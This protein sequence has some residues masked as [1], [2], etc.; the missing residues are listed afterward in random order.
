LENGSIQREK[1]QCFLAIAP[2]D[3]QVPDNIQGII[4][5]R[6]DRLEDNIKRTMQLA[7]VIGRD[8]AFRIL[9]TITGMKKELKSYLLNLQGLEF[10]YE[11]RLFPELEYIFKHALTQE[12]A[13]NSLLLKRRKEIHGKIG[14]AIEELYP[15]RLEEF[16]EMLAYHFDQG[17]VW[18]KAVVY[19]VK[20]GVKTRQ[21]FALQLAFQYF[22]RAKEILEKHPPEVPWQVRYDLFFGRGQILGEMGQWPL[23]CQEAKTAV[24]IAHREGS[25]DRWMKALFA[26]AFAA[27][28]GHLIDDLKATLADLEPIV[29]DDPKSLLGAAALQTMVNFISDDIPSA[30]AGEKNVDELIRLAPNSPF[31]EP[32][33]MWKGFFHRWRGDF[34]KCSQIFERLLPRMKE[35]AP[36]TVYLQSLFFYGLAMGEQGNYQ[37]AIEILEAGRQHGLE[38]GE[39]YSTPKVTN[40]LGWAYHE[41]C[42]FDKAIEYNNLSLDSFKELLGPRTSNLFEI[43]SHTRLNLG[44]NYLMKGNFKKALEHLELVY[45][46][47]LK[48]EY[49]FNLWRYKPRCLL[50]LGELW[51]QK[52]DLSKAQF[53]Q[54]EVTDH[55]WTTKFPYKK[56]QVRSGR[57]QGNIYAAQGRFDAAETELQQSLKCAKQLGNPTQ[58]WKTHQALGD[59][60][61]K[62]SKSEDAKA[63]FQTALKV[64]QGISEGLTDVELKGDYLQSNPIQELFSKA[65]GS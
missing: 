31:L 61:L 57:L 46:N 28:F 38:A 43:E 35:A 4:A 54:D 13:Y 64:V 41:L 39:R 40:S 24:K 18:D 55:G 53:Y 20:A 27:F 49:F 51:L 6:M 37:A 36:A 1:N 16:C 25:R 5:A 21:S 58:L 30:L 44:E 3:I 23:A 42:L 29:A 56:Y 32:A 48:P 26:C 14:K 45:T 15:E 34:K 59:L 47:S 9:Q 17:Q 22:N 7:S 50:G 11:K 63:Q 8:F 2:K 60:L 12:V 10:I 52:G 65:K 33:S 19:Q 62:K